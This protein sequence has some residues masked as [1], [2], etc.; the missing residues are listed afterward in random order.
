MAMVVLMCYAI[1]HFIFNLDNLN[2]ELITFLNKKN[3]HIKKSDQ[4]NCLHC[5]REIF[6]EMVYLFTQYIRI[7]QFIDEYNDFIKWRA[8][9]LVVGCSG[10][11]G[12]SLVFIIVCLNCFGNLWRSNNNT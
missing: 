7:K 3:N 12:T 9:A 10:V 11:T 5:Q 6:Q 8:L 1:F 4:L 2:E